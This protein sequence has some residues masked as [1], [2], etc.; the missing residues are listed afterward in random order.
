MRYALYFALSVIGLTTGTLV[1]FRHISVVAAPVAADTL[2]AP[3]ADT[4]PTPG[5]A[6]PASPTADDYARYA[7]SDEIWRSTHARPFSIA[8]LRARGDGKRT[9]RDSVQDRVFQFVRAGQRGRAITDLEHWVTAHPADDALL[10]SL[11]RLLSEDGRASDAIGRYRQILA[12][13]RRSE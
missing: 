7:E 10:L 8:D 1:T 4:L 5:I 12:L 6:T 9:A 11:A 2:A 13:H 3:T